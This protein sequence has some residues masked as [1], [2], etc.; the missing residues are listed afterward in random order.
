MEDMNSSIVA[1]YGNSS[2]NEYES[3]TALEAIDN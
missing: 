2:N 3:K 1:V